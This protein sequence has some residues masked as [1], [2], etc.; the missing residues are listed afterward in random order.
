MPFGRYPT[1][2][3]SKLPMIGLFKQDIFM[4]PVFYSIEMKLVMV[5]LLSS[6][7]DIALKPL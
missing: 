3:I 4:V 7:F 2:L 1:T 6:I 5:V